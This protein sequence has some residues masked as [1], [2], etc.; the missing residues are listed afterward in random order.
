MADTLV[1]HMATGWPLGR[2]CAQAR[3]SGW[4]DGS[5][6]GGDRVKCLAI[7]SCCSE[8]FTIQNLRRV[9]FWNFVID[10][11]DPLLTDCKQLGSQKMKL[12]V[13]R[14]S[15]VL[16]KWR[17]RECRQQGIELVVGSSSLSSKYR[18][19]KLRRKLDTDRLERDMGGSAA[20]KDTL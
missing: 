19:R 17:H 20:V 15:C 4:K 11:F 1:A 3:P 18:K 14:D 2:W 7:S 13:E 16:G 12:G 8:W 6:L 9:S 10:I 5:Q